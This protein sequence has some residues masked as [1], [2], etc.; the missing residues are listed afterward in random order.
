VGRIGIFN[1]GDGA[2][3]IG[4]GSIAAQ[5]RHDSFS[6]TVIQPRLRF[7]QINLQGGAAIMASGMI[8]V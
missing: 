5:I 1:D 3:D 8:M 7:L 6:P 2:G 4:I